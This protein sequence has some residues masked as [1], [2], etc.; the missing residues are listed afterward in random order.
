V[1]PGIGERPGG[2][3]AWRYYSAATGDLVQ[4]LEIISNHR[5]IYD[6]TGLIGRYDFTFQQISEPARGDDAIDNFPIDHLG[7]KLRPGKES[8]PILEIDHIER[9]SAN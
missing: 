9:P 4:F 3:T 1:A 2:R 7:L 6:K 8:R 5:S